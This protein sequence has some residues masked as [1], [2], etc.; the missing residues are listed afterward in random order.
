MSCRDINFNA[1]LNGCADRVAIL[2][3][4]TVP[5]DLANLESM[6]V[7]TIG[8]E[9]YIYVDDNG[10]PKKIKLNE[11]KTGAIQS[12]WDQS[13]VTAADYIKNKPTI[14]L[15]EDIKS[16]Y[17]VGGIY[18]GQ[19]IP[20]GSSAL[21]ILNMIFETSDIL[22]F[23]F[24]V[25]SNWGE[26]ETVEQIGEVEE[27]ARSEAMLK[28]IIKKDVTLNNN[29]YVFA[30]RKD[31]RAYVSKILQAGFSTEFSVK[32]IVDADGATW[33]MCYYPVPTT[34]TY[35]FLYKLKESEV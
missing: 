27:I 3:N 5:Q 4:E 13:N 35:T 33:N 23:V 31:S 16:F 22:D 25:V 12:D 24:G 8:D 30:I 34:G 14:E 2:K 29:Y 11:V 1:G 32:E 17:N 18:A 19:V 9:S 21:D 28:G 20:A 7:S 15:E 6:E 26:V 10:S